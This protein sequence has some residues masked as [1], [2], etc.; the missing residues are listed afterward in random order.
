[1]TRERL[2]R[3]KDRPFLGHTVDHLLRDG[4]STRLIIVALPES[5]AEDSDQPY[6]RRQHA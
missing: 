2:R 5:T 3:V 4:R 6:A 1:M